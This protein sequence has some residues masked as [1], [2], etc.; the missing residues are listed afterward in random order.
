MELTQDK[1]ILNAMEPI[2]INIF[3][4]HVLPNRTLKC[5][6]DKCKLDI[7]LLT[8]NRVQPHYTST[9][10]GEAY[11]KAL[12]MNSQMLSD[13]IQELARSVLIVEQNPNH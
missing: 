2:V 13:V 6:C 4:E 7:I 5:D 10:V 11:I 12:Y 9:Q 1:T 8:L 3:E